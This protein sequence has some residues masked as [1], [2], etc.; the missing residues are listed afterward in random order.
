M[1]LQPNSSIKGYP[2]G[3]KEENRWLAVD[4]T[5]TSRG[6]LGKVEDPATCGSDEA[7]GRE[8]GENM[9]SLTQENLSIFIETG[10]TYK[11]KKKKSHSEEIRKGRS[12][13]EK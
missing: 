6:G 2:D 12:K 9:N 11:K 8:R 10:F 13:Q 4:E 7:W 3:R 1:S 5:L